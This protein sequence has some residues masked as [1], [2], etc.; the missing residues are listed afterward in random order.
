[1]VKALS[2]LKINLKK[3][4]LIPIGSVDDEEVLAALMDYRVRHLPSFYLGL[5][6]GA[7]LK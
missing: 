3:S 1:M 5:P 2:G 4:G 6:L 7:P